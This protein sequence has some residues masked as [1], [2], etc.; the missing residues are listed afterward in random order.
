[1]H[2]LKD[3]QKRRPSNYQNRRNGMAGNKN[4]ESFITDAIENKVEEESRLMLD[5]QFRQEL[6]KA[7]TAEQ[8]YELLSNKENE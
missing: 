5:E 8:A 2:P 3:A 7:T 1:M 4:M 6:E